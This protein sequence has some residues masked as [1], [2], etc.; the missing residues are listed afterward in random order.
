[1]DMVH[2]ESRNW[3]IYNTHLTSNTSAWHVAEVGLMF[4]N[5]LAQTLR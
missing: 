2:E 5:I 1:M 3:V 4:I